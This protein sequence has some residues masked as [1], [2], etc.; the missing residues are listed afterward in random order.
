MET[1]RHTKWHVQ[2]SHRAWV[3]MRLLLCILGLVAGGATVPRP[4]TR[5][6]VI[7]A[8]E[9][10]VGVV[11]VSLYPVMVMLVS[12]VAYRVWSDCPAWR[13]PTWRTNFIT[14]KEPLHFLHA[15]S[16]AMISFGL[17][18]IAVAAYMHRMLSPEG[19]MLLLSG[20][21]MR[22][23]IIPTYRLFSHKR[24]GNGTSRGCDAARRQ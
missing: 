12:V 20:V 17:G 11:V 14:V 9:L 24:P 21:G 15:L 3:F 19:L 6:A 4:E 5:P 2:P 13:Q 1:H 10:I 8:I 18:A 16:Y 23:A 22:M 7:M